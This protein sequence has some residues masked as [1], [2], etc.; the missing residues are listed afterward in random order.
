ML[1]RISISILAAASMAACSS[2]EDY[3]TT[4]L[5]PPEQALRIDHVTIVDPRNGSL[6]ADMSVLIDDGHIRSIASS[7]NA[8]DDPGVEIVDAAGMYAIPGYNNMHAHTVTDFSNRKKMLAMMLANGI[9]GFRQMSG[10]EAA[11]RAYKLGNFD[12]DL[13][14]ALLIM[15]GEV[16]TPFNAGSPDRA[17]KEVERQAEQGAGFIKVG[18]VDRETF[19]AVMEKVKELGLYAAGHLPGD[20]SLWEAS[21]A[22]YRSIEHFGTGENLFYDCSSDPQTFYDDPGYDPGVPDWLKRMPLAQ[23]MAGGRLKKIMINPAAYAE[24]D[25]IR[26][27][28]KAI[29][30]FDEANCRALARKLAEQ[31]TWQV[32]TLVRLKHQENA[33]LPQYDPES[34]AAVAYFDKDARQVRK[35]VDEKFRSLPE[36]MK[37]T[38][39]SSYQYHLRIIK[40]WDEEN[41]PMMIGT[42]D[43]GLSPASTMQNEFEEL[44]AAGLSPLKLLQMATVDSARFLGRSDTMGLVA[45]G[46]SADIVLLSANPLEGVDNFD[47]VSA[48]VRKGRYFS[49]T[50][51]DALAA[52]QER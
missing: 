6:A 39:R 15:P 11:L 26:Q 21:D 16:L 38:Y 36:D 18:L 51:L 45:P 17:E 46:M 35:E 34:E 32:P 28:Q 22:G 20:V 48:V 42:D 43:S 19:F 30:D 12:F 31:G 25:L 7:A 52:E 2:P 5:P 8:T 33:E 29:D 24:P 9:T 3:D 37:E 13:G 1:R 23:Q 49:K 27:R 41:V 40:I 47:D 4:H 44:A 14:P 50:D 10:N